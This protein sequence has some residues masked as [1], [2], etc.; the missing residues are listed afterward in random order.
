M[1]KLKNISIEKLSEKLKLSKKKKLLPKIL[2][3]VH[4]CWSAHNAGKN[5]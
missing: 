2:V 4:F 1:K 5:L 3:P